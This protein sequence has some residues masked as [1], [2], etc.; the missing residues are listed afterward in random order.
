MFSELIMKSCNIEIDDNFI[1]KC[2]LDAVILTEEQAL[3][4]A[5]YEKV[6]TD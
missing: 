1:N 4:S 3:I 6:S 2:E 5:D